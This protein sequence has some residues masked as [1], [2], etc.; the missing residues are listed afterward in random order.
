MVV[1]WSL[2]LYHKYV[3]RVNLTMI[4]HPKLLTY[5]L[6]QSIIP[7][8]P[9]PFWLNDP[10]A[11]FLG[12]AHVYYRILWFLAWVGSGPLAPDWPDVSLPFFFFLRAWFIACA[13]QCRVEVLTLPAGEGRRGEEGK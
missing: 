10:A 1:S 9:V 12:S 8:P 13:V 3:L 7:P 11:G 4:Q 2:V 6:Y 5:L